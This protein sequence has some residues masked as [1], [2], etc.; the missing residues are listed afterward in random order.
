MTVFSRRIV[1]VRALQM[2][3]ALAAAACGLRAPAPTKRDSAESGDADS[4]AVEDPSCGEPPGADWVELPLAAYPGLSEVGGW[5][6]YD[7]DDALIHVLVA[8]IS[9]G[10]YT[11]VWRVCTHGACELSWEAASTQAVC[12]CHGSR[13][14]PDG[15]VDLGPATR[16]VASFPVSRRGDSLFIGPRR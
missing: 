14:G 2:G 8:H 13:F 16:G 9:P 12:P 10:C 3:A 15:E 5:I 11:A 6:R 7:D 1:L 4:A